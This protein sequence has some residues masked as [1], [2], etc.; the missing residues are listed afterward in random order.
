MS[1]GDEVDACQIAA[2]RTSATYE[3]FV[4]WPE[5]VSSSFTVGALNLFIDPNSLISD[6]LNLAFR[7]SYLNLIV[8]IYVVCF[9]FILV[10]GRFTRYGV[11]NR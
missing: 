7:T 5:A 4:Q 6:Y 9:L 11:S 3:C 2:V 1:A 8:H 10:L